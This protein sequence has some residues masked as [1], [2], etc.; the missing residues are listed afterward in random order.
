[1][2]K[3]DR[4]EEPTGADPVGVSA[5][6]ARTATPAPGTDSAVEP[7]SRP[8]ATEA[9][10]SEP[11]SDFAGKSPTREVFW[12]LPNTV[13]MVRIAVVPV[14]F[15]IPWADGK[16]GSQ[17]M[18][19]AFILAALSDILDGWLARRSGGAA[20][21]RMGKLL[22]PL[23]DKLL[24]TTALIMLV[25]MGRIPLWATGMVVV[26]VGRELAVTGLRGMASSD[27]H[28]VG[29]SWQGKLKSLVQ[30]FSVGAL[31]FHYETI[32]LPAHEVGLT[33]LAVAT[34]LTLWSGY[35][36]FADYFGW[37]TPTGSE[38]G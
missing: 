10:A 26:I 16:G 36:Y 18:A 8:A 12:N 5:A 32:G 34:A 20:I 7:D 17:F 27:G 28:V 14:L 13:T 11:R 15:L 23:A 33:L 31:L 25:A 1:M 4:A 35:V 2:T 30:N 3:A 29:A 38:S 24:V 21:T 9:E 37:S 6:T 19:W 22:D